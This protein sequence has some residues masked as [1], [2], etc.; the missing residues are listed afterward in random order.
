MAGHSHWSSIKH[1]KAAVDTRRGRLWSKLIRN[2]IVA[3]KTGGGNPESNLSLRYAIDKAK[4]A[5]VPNDTID[6]AIKKGTGEIEGEQYEEVVYEGYGPGGVAVMAV[7]LTDNRNRTGPEIRKIFESRGGS[8][9]STGCV[10]WMFEQKGLITVSTTDTDEDRLL[11]IALEAGA[12]DLKQE[13]EEFEIYC[14]PGEFEAVKNAIT[15]A[16]IPIQL[17]EI[18]M[19]PQSTVKLEGDQ[20]KK[21]MDLMETLE[22]HDDTQ[23]V[24]ANFDVPEEVMAEA[25]N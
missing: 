14:P 9:G 6:R 22:D 23:N 20:A 2:V 11:E 17:A 15:A 21:I 19:I 1:R 13:G 18:S 5:N 25:G 7:C 24:Y 3:A 12:E 8:L 16:E 10:A 4:Q